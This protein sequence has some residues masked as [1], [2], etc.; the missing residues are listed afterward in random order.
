MN[1]LRHAPSRQRFRPTGCPPAARRKSMR[2]RQTWCLVIH[3]PCNNCRVLLPP[4]ASACAPSLHDHPAILGVGDAPRCVACGLCCASWPAASARVQV[5]R[6]AGRSLRT[7]ACGRIGP[8]VRSA[9]TTARDWDVLARRHITAFLAALVTPPRVPRRQVKPTRG[10]PREVVY[11]CPGAMCRCSFGPLVWA[12]FRG[13]EL[14]CGP[15]KR[16]WS[17]PCAVLLGMILGELPS[18]CAAAAGGGR[19]LEETT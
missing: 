4:C 10:V 16:S 9:G 2:C 17:T 12:R 6:S 19:L 18:G 11:P 5:P 13:A 15:M 1:K 7:R 14:N 3:D 8:R